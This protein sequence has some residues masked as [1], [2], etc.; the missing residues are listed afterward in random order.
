MHQLFITIAFLCF[1]IGYTIGQDGVIT[2]INPGFE[3]FPRQGKPPKGWQDC[4]FE[5]ETPP[6]VQPSDLISA[7]YFEVSKAAFEGNTYLGMVVRD[8]DTWERVSQRLSSPLEAG[9]C[10]EFSLHLC[11]SELYVSQSRKTYEETNYTTPAKLRIWGGSGHCS[12]RELLAETSQVNNTRW[13]EYNFKFEPKS[14][15][16]YI[17]LEAFYNTPILFPYNGN[18][19]IDNASPIVQ[20]PCDEPQVPVAVVPEPTPQPDPPTPP[21]PN[22]NDPKEDPAVVQS[23]TNNRPAEKIMKELDRKTLKQG[24]TIKI[25]KLF[26]E[27]D[28]SKIKSESFAVLEELYDFLAE[29]ED[30]VVEIAGHTNGIPEHTYCDWLSTARAKAVAD[31]LR[32]RGIQQE[33]LQY[34]GYGKRDPIAS[35]AT[36][37]GRRRNQRVEIKILSFDG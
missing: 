27:A 20:V 13:L 10:Y 29:N 6:D 3:D 37:E 26:F 9:Q 25:D 22:L 33:R 23:T 7:S 21:T 28:S 5:G 19:L 30:V 32:Q 35:N 8:N 12:K 14:T 34:K 4:G 2:L 31:Y 11:R 15:H 16:T 24:Q 18:V 36:S 17:M 1:S